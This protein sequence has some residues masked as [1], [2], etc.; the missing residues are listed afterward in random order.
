M[1]ERR[2]VRI[3]LTGVI[4]IALWSGAASAPAGAQVER[5]TI[6]VEEARCFS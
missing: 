3:F 5:V 6:R 4:A 2:H 1:N